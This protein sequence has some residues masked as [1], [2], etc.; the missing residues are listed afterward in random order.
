MTTEA[1]SL[2]LNHI[3]AVKA[4]IVGVSEAHEV[5][6][7]L[8]E[9][10]NN[11]GAQQNEL[12]RKIAAGYDQIRAGSKFAEINALIYVGDQI[13]S[14]VRLLAEVLAGDDEIGRK[15]VQHIAEYQRAHRPEAVR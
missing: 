12:R 13:H 14:A 5:L 7:A 8:T 10:R 9:S 2:A 15:L 4:T 3:E 6:H 11:T 1:R